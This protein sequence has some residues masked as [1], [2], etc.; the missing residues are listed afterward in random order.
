MVAGQLGLESSRPLS[1]VGPG[2][3][4]PESTRP[5]YFQNVYGICYVSCTC[6]ITH[7]KSKIN[8]K[9]LQLSSLF[10]KLV[11]MNLPLD[12]H[13]PGYQISLHTL[14]IADPPY[15]AHKAIIVF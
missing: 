6:I 9:Q 1:Q 8:I 7:T 14:S 5:V 4:R 13:E 10:I 3:T 2:S 12:C 11:G 15:L